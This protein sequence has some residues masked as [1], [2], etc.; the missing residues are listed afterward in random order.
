MDGEWE[1]AILEKVKPTNLAYTVRSECS[2]VV[3]STDESLASYRLWPFSM[4]IQSAVIR[5]TVSK[6][7]FQHFEFKT[8]VKISL[9]E[10]FVLQ[11]DLCRY[12]DQ[13]LMHSKR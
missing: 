11:Q 5:R 7:D 9:C 6:S 13:K 10:A 1:T 4:L 8:I 3:L 12:C 2:S